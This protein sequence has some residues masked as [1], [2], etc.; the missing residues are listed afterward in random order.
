MLKL[1]KKEEDGCLTVVLAGE[2]DTITSVK[3]DREIGV[4]TAYRKVILDMTDVTY[5]TS[6]GIR[7][8]VGLRK[9]MTPGAKLALTGVQP[10]VRHVLELS[11][12]TSLIGQ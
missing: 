1:H 10:F 8:L 2:M 9:R 12:L 5:V 11:R 4:V 7:V 6:A 3:V